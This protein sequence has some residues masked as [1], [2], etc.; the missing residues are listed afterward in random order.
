MQLIDLRSDTVTQPSSE[1]RQAM[2]EAEVGDDVFGEDPTVNRLQE[3]VAELLGKE[4]ALFVP[5]GTMGNEICI[6]C[7]T[8]PGDEVICES[9]CHIYNYESGAA[10]FLSGVQMRPIV[11]NQGV[12]TAEE[13]E[14]CI[15]PPQDHFARTAVIT[16]ENTHNGAGGT[17]FPLEQ[18]ARLYELAAQRNLKLHIDGA[19]IWNASVAT[20]IA[21]KEY[22]QYCDSISVCFS[23]GLGAPV[24]SA[25]AGSKEFIVEAHRLRKL[26][27]GGMRQVGILA[28]GALHALEH[29][30]QRLTQD[31]EN[32]RLLAQGLL[33]IPGINLDLESVQTNIVLFDVKDTGRSV[34][35]ILEQLKR[36]GVLLVPFG[37]TT[38]RAVTHL[39]VTRQ[40]IEKT[41]AV[42]NEVFV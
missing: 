27:G 19:R 39:H 3:V 1:M 25:V 12:I 7:H 41:L 11:G 37:H 20:G 9:G 24:G 17:I 21:L 22:A 33:E 2:A 26:Y 8:R 29:N 5:S 36:K 42:C 18:L 32:A 16:I 35:E 6:K 4:A 34:A 40:G 28:A 13:V 15:N 10:S 38:L 23:K 31:H 30:L 14:K